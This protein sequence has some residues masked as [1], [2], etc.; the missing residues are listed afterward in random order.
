[1]LEQELMWKIEKTREQLNDIL[2]MHIGQKD[3]ADI[4][5]LSHCL[6]ELILEYMELTK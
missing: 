1:M 6:D 2:V 4:L 3:N 5:H